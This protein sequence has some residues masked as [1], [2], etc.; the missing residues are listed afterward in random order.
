MLPSGDLI[1]LPDPGASKLVWQLQYSALSPI[2]LQA[3]TSLYQA[4]A[5]PVH[6]F[7]FI[8]PAD[9][10]LASSAAFAA[11]AWNI[12][13]TITISSG[14]SDPVGGTN[15]S[16]LTNTGQAS[17]AVT[18]TLAI[19]AWYEYCFS[20]YA[21]SNQE[22]T[23]TL[24]MQGAA[25]QTANACS[26]G[27][28]W[29]RIIS[30]SALSDS[31]AT[32]TVGIQLS[33]GQQVMVYGPQLEPQ[34]APSRYRSTASNGGVYPNAHWGADEFLVTA[35]APNLFATAFTIETAIQD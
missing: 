23:L 12:P 20:L 26:V 17:Q 10:M 31:S 33:A 1:L 11:P 29:S 25:S 22:S 27:V 28:N 16:I 24:T 34:G 18:Q 15:A 4:C 7:T 35:Q 3:L 9:N 8:D 21:V 14:A 19:P 30:T 6:A 5:G 2:D 13:A 32:L